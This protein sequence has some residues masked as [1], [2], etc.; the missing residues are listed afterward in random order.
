MATPAPPAASPPQ[1]GDASGPAKPAPPHP[2]RRHCAPERSWSQG[3]A[4]PAL[5]GRQCRPLEGVTPQAARGW[6]HPS[7]RAARQPPK[8]AISPGTKISAQMI[9]D[10]LACTQGR[11]PKK[12]PAAVRPITQIEPP[13]TL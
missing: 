3:T 11:L 8:I 13:T 1:G 9:L 6:A 7:A 10:R 4:E 2:C 12:Y 5:P